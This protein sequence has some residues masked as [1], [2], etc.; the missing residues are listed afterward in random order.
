MNF[1]VASNRK[2]AFHICQDVF[3]PMPKPNNSNFAIFLRIE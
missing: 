2:K 3:E 1:I